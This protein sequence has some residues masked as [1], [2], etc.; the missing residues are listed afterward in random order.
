MVPGMGHCGGGAGPNR[1]GNGGSAT[2]SDPDHDVFTALERWVERGTAPERI[3]GTGVTTDEPTRTLTRPLCP[4]P[5][6]AKYRGAG[7]VTDA[8]NFICGS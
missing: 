3:I 6:R 1:F 5:M 2:S 4:Y 7:D 8:A